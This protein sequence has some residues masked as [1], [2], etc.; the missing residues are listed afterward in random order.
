MSSASD[1]CA[2]ERRRDAD[3]RLA[4]FIIVTLAA[5]GEAGADEPDRRN[6]GVA[7]CKGNNDEATATRP[8]EE[9]KALVADGMNW[10]GHCERQLV[11]ENGCRL[12]ETDAMSMTVCRALAGCHSKRSGISSIYDKAS[13]SN[14]PNTCGCDRRRPAGPA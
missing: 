1:D 9:H 13:A 3:L 2:A 11:V 14:A 6:I 4:F 7:F 12:L 5:V 8:V 10:I